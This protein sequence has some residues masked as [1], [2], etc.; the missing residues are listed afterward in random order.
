MDNKKIA[1]YFFVGCI[2]IGVA[3]G[4]FF[5]KP[6]VGAVLG[7]GLGFIFKAIYMHNKKDQQ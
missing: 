5:R 1:N 7:V 2:M 3:A 6:A 4:M